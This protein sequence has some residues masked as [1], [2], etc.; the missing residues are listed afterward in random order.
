VTAASSGALAYQWR[1]NGS[2]IT[3]ATQASFT[4]AAPAVSDDGAYGC[5]VT[6]VLNGTPPRP[7]AMP[8]S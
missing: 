7:P 8:A 6:S 1:R 5:V 3:G 4:L 2:P